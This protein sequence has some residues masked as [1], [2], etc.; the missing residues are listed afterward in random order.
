MALD[1]ELLDKQLTYVRYNE[2]MT[3]AILSHLHR[4]DFTQWP[5]NKHSGNLAAYT[6]AYKDGARARL[7]RMLEMENG[8]AACP[9][10]YALTA[11]DPNAVFSLGKGLQETV[12]LG[13]G[14]EYR[15]VGL[16]FYTPAHYTA[17]VFLRGEWYRYDDLGFATK[18]TTAPK[19]RA[20]TST[21]TVTTRAHLIPTT[22]RDAVT[23][24]EGFHHRSYVF[25]L[26][27]ELPAGVRVQGI[28]WT[29]YA[30]PQYSNMGMLAASDDEQEDI[31]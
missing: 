19:T 30:D 8:D 9:S 5:C 11:A 14:L 26:I 2:T 21:N 24:P 18:K 22:F 17:S 15:L 29:L 1:R 16:T 25:T 20:A 31:A 3:E 4:N 28:D 13:P 6:I 27:G 23:P 10:E 7:P 12:E